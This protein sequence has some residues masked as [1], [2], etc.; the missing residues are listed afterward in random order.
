MILAHP[1]AGVCITHLVASR[2]KSLNTKQQA[3][4]WVTGITA[5]ILPDLDLVLTP[6]FPDTSH[7]FFLT[8][9]PMFYLVIGLLFALALLYLEKVKGT[10]V[11]FLEKLL[12]IA[13]V[14]IFIHIS[15]DVIAGNIRLFW[16][17]DLSTY[18]LIPVSS[19]NWV[20]NYLRSPASVIELITMICGIISLIIIRREKYFKAALAT[21][22][23]W[24]TI[25][26]IMAFTL[27]Q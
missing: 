25:C 10:N 14:N 27:I 4:V 3:L 8:H 6:F 7:H 13:L 22:A 11:L 24:F 19:I 2:W 12:I 23:W 16:P 15:L 20:E 5:S 21:F 9:T 1:F 17:V 26:I 18:N